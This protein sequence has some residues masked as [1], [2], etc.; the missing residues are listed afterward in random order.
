MRN[1]LL[2]ALLVFLPVMMSCVQEIEYPEQAGKEKVKVSFDLDVVDGVRSSITPDE[3]RIGNANIYIYERGVLVGN[4]YADNGTDVVLTLTAGVDYN[5]YVLANVGKVEAYPEEED[6]IRNYTCRIS[7]IADLDSCLPLAGCLKSVSL[8]KNGQK[9]IVPVERLVS[10]VMFSVDK[11]ALEGLEITSVRLRQSSLAVSPFVEKGSAAADADMVADGDYCSADDIR[12]LNSGDLVCFYALENCQGVLLPDNSDPWKKVLDDNSEKSELCT[13]LEVSCIFGDA[14][15]YEGEVMYRLYLGQDNC[16]DF[17]L[18]RNT[19]LDVSLCLTDDGLG[20]GVSWRVVPAFTVREGFASGW[21][22]RGMHSEYDLY[23]GERFEYS[24]WMSDEMLSHLDFDL[25]NCEVC[26]NGYETEGDGAIRFSEFRD[27]GDGGLCVDAVCVRPCEGE[28]VLRHKN[29]MHLAVLGGDVNVSTPFIVISPDSYGDGTEMVTYQSGPIACDINGEDVVR[30]V[31][32]TDSQSLN[33]NA[34][35]GCGLDFSVFDFDTS[36]SSSYGIGSAMEISLVQGQEADDGPVFTLNVSCVNDGRDHNLNMAL[37]RSCDAAPAAV[38][39]IADHDLDL[40]SS[41]RIEVGSLPVGLTLVDNG[42]A[43]Y[44]TPRM[45]VKV[46]NPSNLPLEVDCWQFQLGGSKSAVTPGSDVMNKVENDL[47]LNRMEYVVNQYNESA[48]TVYGGGDSFISERNAFGDLAIE[49]GEALVY[50]LDG[51]DTDGIMAAKSYDGWEHSSLSHHMSVRFSDGSPVP[52]IIVNDRLSDGS[53]A[54]DQMYGYGGLNDR[55]VWLYC[56]NERVLAPESL[57]D[58]Y[59]GLTP[60]NLRSMKSQTPVVGTMKYDKEDGQLYVNA[61][62]LGSEGLILTSRCEAHADGYVQ[63]HPKGTWRDPVD[64]WCSDELVKSSTGFPV[65]YSGDKV[66]ADGGT[67]RGVFE[68]IYNHKF[69]D[70]WNNIG[71]SNSYLHRA[72]PISL[73]MKMF[74]K[75]HDENDKGAYLFRPVYNNNVSFYHEEEGA[76]YEVPASFSYSTFSFV[77]VRNR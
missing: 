31:Y 68:K 26:F 58:I 30:Y 28:I 24:V 54:F 13:Y 15:M 9:I 20:R 40:E 33:L 43:G 29:G 32:V 39:D 12:S 77:E 48:G 10:K 64:N 7:S 57:Y 17:N 74:F 25:D 49:D 38:F 27:D 67:V 42:W 2:L 55:G 23:V 51:I 3:N 73:D 72:H 16:T 18:K 76:D 4:A 47:V 61:Y 8:D 5:V 62:S 56:G 36:V 37:L 14:G 50:N 65:L 41:M 53:A 52:E 71:S 45:A 46:D 63:T 34:S 19:V 11:S 69:P 22:S 6:M 66:S 1:I 75:I 44:G 59:P 21:I 70:S 35:S 60:D